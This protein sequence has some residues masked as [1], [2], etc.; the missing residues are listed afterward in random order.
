MLLWT[1]G[2]HV[3][4]QISIFIFSRYKP[5]DGSNGS[6]IFRFLRNLYT[7]FHSGCTNLHS[8]QQCTS[9]PFPPHPCQYLLCVDFLMMAILTG[10]R[11][12]H[13]CFDL[14]FSNNCEAEYLFMCL[15]TYV[16]CLQK[17]VYSGLWPIF[18]LGCLFFWYWVVQTV[19]IFWIL[20][21][22]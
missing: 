2:L 14:H 10:V 18:W 15:L 22:C 20:T 21:A 8:H 5:R 7:V 11:W 3:S 17:N 12:S 4:F 6:S 9:V 13:C 19:Y 1:L 16:C